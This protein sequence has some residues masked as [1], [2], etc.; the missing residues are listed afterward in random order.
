M[1]E[2]SRLRLRELD[3]GDAE[4]ILRLF[5]DA[6]FVRYIGDRGLRTVADAER[7]LS[8][9]VVPGYRQHGFG[10]WHLSR[11]DNGDALGICGL[12]RRPGLDDVDLGY[13][14]LPEARRQGFV[15]EAAA[16]CLHYAHAL[17]GLP[18]VAA[19]TRYDNHPSRQVLE[20]LG[21]VHQRALTLPGESQVIALYL[22]QSN[23]PR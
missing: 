18:R 3:T 1:L 12:L 17:L 16:A 20:Q 4:F 22:R 23:A 15:R 2:T 19:I 13:A 6:D 21:F 9:R 8:E 11:L 14:L 10:L 7:Y 5:S